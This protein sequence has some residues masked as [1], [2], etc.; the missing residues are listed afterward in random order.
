MRKWLALAGFLV[1]TYAVSGVS[2]L[3]TASAIPTWYATLVKP[4]FNPPNEVFGPVWTLLYGLMA[5]AAWLVWQR[6]PSQ[7]R[8]RALLLFW[9]QL[10]LNFAWS[11]LFFGQHLIGL[12][13]ADI[14]LLWL[15]ILVTCSLFF[16][17]S[18]TAGWMLVPYLAWVGFASILNFEI[19][20][21]N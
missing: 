19:W 1:V 20:R 10:G 18:K 13:L 6:P 4:S 14:V 9:V 5:I 15:A 2:A 11:L 8:S 16:R 21:L 12:A 17:L 7:L 3:F